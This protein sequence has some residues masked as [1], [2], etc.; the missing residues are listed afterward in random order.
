MRRQLGQPVLLDHGE[1][2]HEAFRRLD[3]L[4]IDDKAVLGHSSEENRGRVDVEDLREKTRSV[5][6]RWSNAKNDSP[7]PLAL[8]CRCHRASPWLHA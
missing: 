2:A 3:N 5:R 8:I 1:V 4:V 7:L 6:R